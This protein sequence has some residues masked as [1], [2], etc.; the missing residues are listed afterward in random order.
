VPVESPHRSS[1]EVIAEAVLAL[2]GHA[3]IREVEH[4]L[5]DSPYG[6]PADVGSTMA[7][8]CVGAPASST[9]PERWRVLERIRRGVYRHIFADAV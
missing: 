5:A 4:F 8:M 7:A 3:S 1:Y 6:E 2:G 9:A